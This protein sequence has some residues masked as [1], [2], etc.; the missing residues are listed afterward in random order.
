VTIGEHTVTLTPVSATYLASLPERTAARFIETH[1]RAELL[2]HI[3]ETVTVTLDLRSTNPSA[4]VWVYPYQN[5]GVSIADAGHFATTSTYQTFSF[6]TKVKDWGGDIVTY[7]SG[8]IGIYDSPGTAGAVYVRNMTV[9]SGD[10]QTIDLSCLVD[11]VEIHHG[12]DDTTSQPDA[13]A[14]T[15]D[16]SRDETGDLT[17]PPALEIGATITVSTQ[18]STGTKSTRFVGRVTDLALGWDDAGTETPNAGVAQI[19]ATGILDDT[20]RRVVGDTPWT[21]ELD[22]ARVSRIMA[23]AGVTLDPAYSDPGTVQ[24]L[25]RDVDAQAALDLSREVAEHASGVVWQ[26]RAGQIRYADA[27]HRRGIAV[28]LTLDACDVLVTPTWKRTLAG[29]INSVTLAYGVAPDGGEQP[30]VTSTNQASIDRWGTFGYSLTTQLAAQ[31]DAQAMAS[32]LMGRNSSPVWIM[33]ALP[34]DAANLA[35]ADYDALVGLDMHSLVSLTGLPALGNAP[36]SA[37]LWVEGWNETL[38]AGGHEIE[39]VVSGYCRT[40]PPPRWDDVDPT[41]TWDTVS[42][43]LTWDSATCLGPPVDYGRWNDVPASLRW[44]QVP[45]TTTWDN[46]HQ[47]SRS[48]SHG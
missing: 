35:D 44:N 28:S 25:A 40:V 19:I 27:A 15:L 46:Y 21:Q 23:A 22:G 20:T 24:I 39:L 8:S 3:G 42:A 1:C 41:W 18:T 34:V 10:G 4:D 12:R 43:A 29:L 13:P 48:E 47:A 11:Q 14:V 5:T 32:L 38:Y 9:R 2:N 30:T 37:T 16:L 7:T 26:T 45:P 31:A 6:V 17:L 36:T 33:A